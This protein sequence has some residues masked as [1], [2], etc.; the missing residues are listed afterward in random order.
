MLIL[1]LPALEDVKYIK[2]SSDNY[3]NPYFNLGNKNL[4]FLDFLEVLIDRMDLEKLYV[5]EIFGGHY[6]QKGNELL[7]KYLQK[8]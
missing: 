1:L 2:S 6:N 5:D 8:K 3:Y 4:I 7:A